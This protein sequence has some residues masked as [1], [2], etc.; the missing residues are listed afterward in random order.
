MGS[1]PTLPILVGLTVLAFL[2]TGHAVLADGL[3]NENAPPQEIC[4]TCHGLDGIS[5]MAKFPKLAGQKADYLERQIREFR[6]GRRRND[7]GQMAT[8][9]TEISEEQ[10]ADVARY[11]SSLPPPAPQPGEL[12]AA[13]RE[14]AETLFN[15][16]DR[17]AGVPACRGCH[18]AGEQAGNG[19]VEGPHLTAQHEAYLAKQL[20]DFRS[21]A[22]ANDAGG[23]MRRVAARLSDADIA[24]LARFLAAMPRDRKAAGVPRQ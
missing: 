2:D 4:G 12:D 17:L 9:V 3:G 5:R 24:A 8:V 23:V 18:G 10:I 22:R 1:S 14:R 15:A 13:S 21:R 11:F 6:E 20:R 7:S 19:R 16:G